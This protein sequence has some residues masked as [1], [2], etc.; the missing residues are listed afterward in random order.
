MLA[1]N[2]ETGSSGLDDFA[3]RLGVGGK[4]DAAGR[5]RFQHGAGDRVLSARGHVQV[6]AGQDFS[7]DRGGCSSH[8]PEP[9]GIERR[10]VRH[11]VSRVVAVMEDD[12]Q[13]AADD[14]L[15]HDDAEHVGVGL[16]QSVRNGQEPVE[17]A[18][19]V[20]RPRDETDDP[21]SRRDH[22]AGDQPRRGGGRVRG[23]SC[24][25]LGV[26]AIVQHE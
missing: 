7:H 14:R 22:A 12:V 18:E 1:V 8:H 9:V 6:A 16:K 2:Q 10:L 19:A 21:R 3:V 25:S 4:D 5:H 11:Q 24:E 13:T 23:R 26:D 17:P 20:E 15:A